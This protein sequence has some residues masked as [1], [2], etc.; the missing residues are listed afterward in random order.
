[1]LFQ[2]PNSTG[3]SL[4]KFEGEEDRI[5]TEPR[6]EVVMANCLRFVK[7]ILNETNVSHG[8][9]EQFLCRYLRPK[10]W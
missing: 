10:E 7:L 2:L 6:L 9:H 4:R 5:S 3:G 1:M 8:G